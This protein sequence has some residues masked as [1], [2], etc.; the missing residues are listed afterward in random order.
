MVRLR[1]KVD[2]T[3]LQIF[4]NRLFG[5]TMPKKEKKNWGYKNYI[6][7]KSSNWAKLYLG[8]QEFV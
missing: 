1:I 4:E 5:K 7:E 6:L 2:T 3:F 8:D